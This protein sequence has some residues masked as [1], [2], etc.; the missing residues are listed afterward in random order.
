MIR[1]YS[2]ESGGL[3]SALAIG[4]ELEGPS[5][6]TTGLPL[7]TDDWPFLYME[8][9]E[10]PP[11]YVWIMLMFVGTGLFAVALSGQAKPRHAVRMGP[12][13]LMGAAFLL[14]E[15]K[16]IIQFS[17]LFGATWMVNSLV[18]FAILASV[19]LANLIVARVQIRTP[20]WPFALLL[21][22]LVVTIVLPLDSLLSIG[23]VGVRYVV[24]SAVIFSPIFCANL[25]FGWL[26]KGTV[27]SDTAFGWN[28]IGT[29]IGGA[30]EY[31]SL[32]LGY[33]ALAVVVA[34]LYLATAVWAMALRP[35]AAAGTLK[36]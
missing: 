7:A 1:T 34:G 22:S 35:R 20:R 16:S 26:F 25:V 29:M 15:T 13:L 30:F 19:L 10:L 12:F 14:L 31:T 33:R 9:R 11:L 2:D 28:L 23:N 24:S 32:T 5:R 3:L 17:L 4:P 18:F 27:Q 36:T 6:A 8:D 21:A